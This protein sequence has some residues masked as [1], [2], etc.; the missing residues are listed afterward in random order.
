MCYV[1]RRSTVF[2]QVYP[3]TDEFVPE[4]DDSTFELPMPVP[5]KTGDPVLKIR[6]NMGATRNIEVEKHIALMIIKAKAP[7]S[8]Q[9]NTSSQKGKEN[10]V[11]ISSPIAIIPKEQEGKFKTVSHTKQEPRVRLLH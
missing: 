2:G 3:N 1:S 9:K 5:V 6:K 8:I 7:H 11:N 10:G 4:N